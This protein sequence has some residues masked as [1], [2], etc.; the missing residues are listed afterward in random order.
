MKSACGRVGIGQGLS[1]ATFAA[2]EYGLGI[3]DACP[4]FI[5]RGEQ[6]FSRGKQP[7][8]WQESD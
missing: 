1:G 6:R 4:A 7:E 3:I 5:T 2:V 8:N